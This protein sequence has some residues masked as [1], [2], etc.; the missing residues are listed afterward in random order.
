MSKKGTKYIGEQTEK[1]M[2]NFPFSAP[3]ISHELVYAIA[4]IKKAAAL[5]N[6]KSGNLDL[7]RKNA[8]IKSAD[9]IL[10]GKFDSE[11]S[12]SALQGGAGTSIHMNV[13]EVIA[14]RASEILNEKNISK[15]TVDSKL[16][17]HYI[18]HVNL[19][20]S[21][22]DVLPSALKIASE[23]LLIQLIKDL[24]KV[25]SIF[26]NKAKE[27]KNILKLGRTHLQDAVPTTLG[28][29]FKAYADILKRDQNRL[30]ESLSYFY[31]L[32]LGGTAIGDSINASPEYLKLI[33]VELN[34]LTG[35]SFKPSKNFMSQTSSQSDFVM[36]SCMVTLLSLDASKIANDIRFMAS[37]PKGGIGEIELGE[38]QKGSSI[39]PGKVN[40]ILPEAVNQ[41]YFWVS[42]NNLSIEHA[43]QASQLELGVMGPTI[44]DSLIM[45]LKLADEVLLKFAEDCIKNIK[46]NKERCLDLLEKSSAYATL[47]SPVLGYDTV[48]EIVK[49]SFKE[50]LS[51]KELVLS[52]KLISEK[53]FNKILKKRN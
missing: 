6:F 31:E 19:S 9:E 23:K 53:E 20:Q 51:F 48:A 4:L 5:A 18:D 36:L 10:M 33:Y 25:I 34:K 11:F 15:K 21:T 45:S 1:A 41:L 50:N 49:E 12:L 7:D 52:K 29:E 32:N 39:M 44:S 16:K 28:A 24:D 2:K 26:E 43:A 46:A 35:K 40:P 3:P 14:L 47:F 30:K 17:V 8:I 38:L 13:N 42:G 37:G 27:F 22:N